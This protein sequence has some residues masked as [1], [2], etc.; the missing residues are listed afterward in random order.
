M[1]RIDYATRMIAARFGVVAP[2]HYLRNATEEAILLKEAEVLVGK[3]AWRDMENVEDLTAEYWRLRQLDTE[4]RKLKEQVE[5]NRS[6]H[7]RVKELATKPETV[8]SAK[9]EEVQAR[10][11]SEREILTDR[12]Q[13]L[14]EEIK[15]AE[16]LRRRF[17]GFKI[18]L[19]VLKAEGAR[20]E[21]LEVVR[22]Q[23]QILKGQYGEVARQVEG[24]REGIRLME[25]K[26]RAIESEE[27]NV[28]G[29]VS[30]HERI[31]TREVS[32]VSRRLVET[33]SRLAVIEGEKKELFGAIGKYLC[34]GRQPDTA[35][36]K[37]VV[38]RLGP[39]VIRARGLAKSIEFNRRL[40]DYR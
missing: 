33:N 2:R 31:L 20:P 25:E 30:H 29:Q 26:V 13:A 38:R 6:E 36:T 5:I 16:K 21:E 11:E 17:N 15:G 4:E 28:R 8:F 34:R 3:M 19:S 27:A 23:L 12:L 35:E 7:E 22:G 24:L 39:L 32:E 9:L 10:L 40:A 37:E 18:K 14:Q 1:N